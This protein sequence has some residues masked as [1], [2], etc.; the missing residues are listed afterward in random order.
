PVNATKTT[1]GIAP[2][3][4]EEEKLPVKPAAVSSKAPSPKKAAQPPL[5]LIVP[6]NLPLATHIYKVKKG[7]TLWAI[8]MRFT[9]NPYNY[10]SVAQENEINNPDLIFPEQP[11]LLKRKNGYAPKSNY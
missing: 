6:D 3:I 2:T 11:I 7:D 10:P 4:K 8:S 9:G 1:P 5:T